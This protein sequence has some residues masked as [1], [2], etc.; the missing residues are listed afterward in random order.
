MPGSCH[1]ARCESQGQA[2]KDF[3]SDALFLGDEMVD[4]G[5]LPTSHWSATATNM[6]VDHD[7]TDPTL[8]LIHI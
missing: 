8:S 4:E 2:K 3:L 1:A 6:D 5:Q 7:F